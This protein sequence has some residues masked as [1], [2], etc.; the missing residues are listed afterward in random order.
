[1]SP[2]KVFIP[3][4]LWERIERAAEADRMDPAEWVVATLES[5]LVFVEKPE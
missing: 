2:P 3:K 4:E 1:M 5:M